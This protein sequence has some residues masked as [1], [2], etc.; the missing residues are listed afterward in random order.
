MP[1]RA[2]VVIWPAVEV[3]EFVAHNPRIFVAVA[4]GARVGQIEPKAGLTRHRV[5]V[6]VI[7][8]TSITKGGD[9]LLVHKMDVGAR[10]PAIMAARRP[11]VINRGAR[12]G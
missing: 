12:R 11:P 4:I 9:V 5:I 1:P 6:R 8:L 2:G 7:W 10:I 3:A